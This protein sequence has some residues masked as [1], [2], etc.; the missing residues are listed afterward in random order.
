LQPLVLEVAASKF[1]TFSVKVN[2]TNVQ[3]SIAALKSEWDKF[4]PESIFEYHFL[5][6]ALQQ[7]YENEQRLARVIGYFSIFTYI[8]AGLGL[9]GLA[10]Y[11]NEQRTREV[12]IR[13]VL[14][15]T[16][17]S[18]FVTLS[19]EFVKLIAVAFVI[20]IPVSIY[21]ALQ[22]LEGFHYKTSLSVV[23]F[24]IVLCITAVIVLFT[25]SYQTLRAS[26]TSPAEVLKSE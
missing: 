6:E 19:S 5:D 15:A 26:R 24:L 9:F 12:G 2:G 16:A 10:A 25:I 21:I 17:S 7:N 3:E 14:G 1:S 11:I 22:W 20:A 18:I 4:F 8:I 13:K 23:M